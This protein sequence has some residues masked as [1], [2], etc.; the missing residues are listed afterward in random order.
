MSNSFAVLAIDEEPTHS[1]STPRVKTKWEPVDLG[2]LLGRA[3]PRYAK[4]SYSHSRLPKRFSYSEQ[5]QSQPVT[6]RA[7]KVEQFPSLG[8]VPEANPLTGS[9][10]NGVESIHLAKDRPDPEIA[11]RQE[12]ERQAI[13]LRRQ[14]EES[15]EEQMFIDDDEMYSVVRRTPSPSP[16]SSPRASPVSMM[17][18]EEDLRPPVNP[19]D[20]DWSAW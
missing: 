9:W 1:P 3:P 12:R 18:T 11:R 6:R 2:K 14:Q 4:H 20:I 17:N 19:A 5:S 13:W 7:R 10:A 8:S 16:P 15:R